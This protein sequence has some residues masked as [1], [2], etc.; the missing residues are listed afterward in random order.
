M[1]SFRAK[2]VENHTLGA[3]KTNT[4]N[5]TERGVPY[6]SPFC[7]RGLRLFKN[8]WRTRTE[9]TSWCLAAAST[10]KKP[11]VETVMLL[12]PSLIPVM[13]LGSVLRK[14]RV[15]GHIR[16]VKLEVK[17]GCHWDAAC[18][19]H[20]F[21]LIF[22]K[23]CQLMPFIVRSEISV[24]LRVEPPFPKIEQAKEML[25]AA[26]RV[27]QCTRQS[28]KLLRRTERPIERHSVTCRPVSNVV[29][30]PWC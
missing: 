19:Y 17:S 10:L 22:L 25:S 21:Q 26:S 16:V 2:W 14:I 13:R 3:A 18:S 4:A 24:T 11:R 5:I 23:A 7:P 15:S 30:L 6:H 27:N 20:Q 9:R 8:N 1:I 29:L 28:W 12:F